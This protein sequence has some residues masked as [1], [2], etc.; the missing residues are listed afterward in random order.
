[1]VTMPNK[2]KMWLACLTVVYNSPSLVLDPPTVITIIDLLRTFDYQLMPG[3][4]STIG[5]PPLVPW[6]DV[7]VSFL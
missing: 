4:Y 3:T 2:A 7:E 6:G 5:M 1:M